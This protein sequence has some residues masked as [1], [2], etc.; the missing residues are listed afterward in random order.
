MWA[1]KTLFA[2]YRSRL[3]AKRT[4][5]AIRHFIIS[6]RITKPEI[7]LNFL[8]GTK[9]TRNSVVGKYHGKSAGFYFF[10]PYNAR[11]AVLTTASSSSFSDPLH[12]SGCASFTG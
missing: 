10:H 1:D 7:C 6:L 11:L 4:V 5:S 8:I 9:Y 3:S 2:V 12:L